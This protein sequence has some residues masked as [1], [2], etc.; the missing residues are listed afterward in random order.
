MI[1][2]CQED[3]STLFITEQNLSG[4]MLLHLGKGFRKSKKKKKKRNEEVIFGDN[5]PSH[6]NIKVVVTSKKYNRNLCNSN[7]SLTIAC[8]C[9]SINLYQLLKMI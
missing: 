6:K 7:F 5:L 8:S 9:G 4:S 2:R 1:D 3:L